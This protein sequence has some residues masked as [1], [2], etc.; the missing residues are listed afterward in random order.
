MSSLSSRTRIPDPKRKIGT[1]NSVEKDFGQCDEGRFPSVSSR[2]PHER[3]SEIWDVDWEEHGSVKQSS[4]SFMLA[5]ACV[6]RTQH[7]SR[8]SHYEAIRRDA[9]FPSTSIQ[10]E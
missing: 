9:L 7:Q 4:G 2:N 5:E 10:A 8:A 6:L 1:Q 3:L